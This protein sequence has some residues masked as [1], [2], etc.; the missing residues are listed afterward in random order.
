MG[1]VRFDSSTERQV[2]HV[3]SGRVVWSKLALSLLSSLVLSARCAASSRA[4]FRR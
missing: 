3:C 4:I 1:A 2:F